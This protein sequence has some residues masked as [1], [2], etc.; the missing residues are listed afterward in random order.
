MIRFGRCALAVC[1]SAVLLI[2]LT[3]NP[4]TAQAA[5]LEAGRKVFESVCAACHGVTGR[6]DPSNFVV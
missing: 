3:C 2:G 1:G 5:D 6:P 4:L